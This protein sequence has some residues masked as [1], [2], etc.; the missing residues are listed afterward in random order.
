[1]WSVFFYLPWRKGFEKSNPSCGG[2][3]GRRQLDCGETSIFAKGENANESLILCQK[4]N[5]HHSVWISFLESDPGFERAAPVCTLVQKIESGRA[6]FSPWENP[7][8]CERTRI[9]VGTSPFC[10]L[11]MDFGGIRKVKY[12]ACTVAFPKCISPNL[13]Q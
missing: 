1:M 12:I 2:Q 8:T 11:P 9:G 13:H 7:W 3:L 5:P 10:F 6:I 4:R